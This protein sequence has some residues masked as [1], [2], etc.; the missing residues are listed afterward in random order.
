MKSS[1]QSSTSS[2]LCVNHSHHDAAVLEAEGAALDVGLDIE[3][4][5]GLGTD[6]PC[7][8]DKDVSSRPVARVAKLDKDG[9]ILVVARKVVFST[10][11]GGVSLGGVSG[12]VCRPTGLRGRRSVPLFGAGSTPMESQMMLYSS[13]FS[14]DVSVMILACWITS[15]YSRNGSIR[16]LG[17]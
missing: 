6:E 14:G 3:L 2:A 5:I 12:S 15:C 13:I 11:S 4:G 16:L 7:G 8:L 10:G 17:L 9:R 1:T